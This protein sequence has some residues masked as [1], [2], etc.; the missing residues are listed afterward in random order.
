[1]IAQ[2]SVH[3]SHKDGNLL[4]RFK[5]TKL[6][7]D[8]L[9]YRNVK[10][11]AQDEQPHAQKCQCKA[12]QQY[13]AVITRLN[14]SRITEDEDSG[15]VYARNAQVR[16]PE[17]IATSKSR[18]KWNNPNRPYELANRDRSSALWRGGV[19]TQVRTAPDYSVTPEG[20]IILN[21]APAP[22]PA[23]A[24]APVQRQRDNRTTREKRYAA[25]MQ[26][27][28]ARNAKQIVSSSNP[29][30]TPMVTHRRNG[31]VILSNN[32]IEQSA[33]NGAVVQ[34]T[35]KPKNASLVNVVTLVNR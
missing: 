2:F 27:F 28:N 7:Y 5:K 33:S 29:R 9:A 30:I 10:R 24:T 34:H 6:P 26:R 25:R 14:P 31:Q 8:P 15:I 19:Y 16:T 3:D 22:T 32:R 18:L 1:V 17:D 23:P 13:T 21:H 12:C 4:R 11:F 20:K 35:S